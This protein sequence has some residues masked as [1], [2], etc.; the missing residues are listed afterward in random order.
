M[1]SGSHATL[2]WQENA[3]ARS[4]PP[5]L[6][7]SEGGTERCGDLSSLNI[8]CAAALVL[9]L[10]AV[11]ASAQDES[12]PVLFHTP[13]KQAAVA[14]PLTIEGLL[15]DGQKIEKVF[16]RFRHNGSSDFRTVEMEVQYGDIYRG[17]I[18]AKAVRIPWLEYF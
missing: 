3:G 18:P 4:C 5:F 12:R 2:T 16:L 6:D 8:T 11:P 10:V 14:E 9:T 1:V 15:I 13:A 17:V 7:L